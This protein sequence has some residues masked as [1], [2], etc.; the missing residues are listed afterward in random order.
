M[1]PPTSLARCVG[2]PPVAGA[3]VAPAAP[4]V[5]ADCACAWGGVV[6]APWPF[7]G[8]CGAAPREGGAWAAFAGC[9]PVFG[10]AAGCAGFAA[11]ASPAASITPTTVWIGTVRS[12]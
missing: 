3:P 1:R 2:A 7:V 8:A 12:E 6:D 5:A 10:A 4:D 9:A 11:V